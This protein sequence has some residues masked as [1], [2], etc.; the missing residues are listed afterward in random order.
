MTSIEFL[1]TG[2][3]PAGGARAASAA[4]AATA[5]SPRAAPPPS[6][7]RDAMWVAGAVAAAGARAATPRGAAERA[8][9]A[10]ARPRS[11][12]GARDAVERVREACGRASG[13]GEGVSGAGGRAKRGSSAASARRP[14]PPRPPRGA[15]GGRAGLATLWRGRGRTWVGLESRGGSGRARGAPALAASLSLTVRSGA[16]GQTLTSRPYARRI[17]RSLV[18]RRAG[19]ARHVPR[20]RRRLR[21]CFLPRPAQ[22][23]G[24]RHRPSPRGRH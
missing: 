21:H 11:A 5:R 17:E 1:G 15:P 8:V 18:A 4:A 10:R 22:A 9:G 12:I 13:G 6:L 16:G 2:V 23:G 7:P 14:R 20:S 19:R 24:C 3:A